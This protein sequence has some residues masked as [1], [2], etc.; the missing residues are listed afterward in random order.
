MRRVYKYVLYDNVTRRIAVRKDGSKF[1]IP[2][3]VT[4]R[5]CG[6][7]KEIKGLCIQHGV[8]KDLNIGSASN[9]ESEYYYDFL[10]VNKNNEE[11]SCI[12]IC[13]DYTAFKEYVWLPHQVAKKMG[14]K[15]FSALDTLLLESFDESYSQECNMETTT[16]S[17]LIGGINE[18]ISAFRMLML[19]DVVEMTETYRSIE[20]SLKGAV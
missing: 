13:G 2:E 10:T 3:V 6:T 5:R 7:I 20:M 17:N 4:N 8:I 18:T 9:I 15:Y 19:N 1:Y 14:V 16:V 12:C 11:V